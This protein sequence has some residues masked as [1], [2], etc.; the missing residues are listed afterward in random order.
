MP[1]I[2]LTSGF[3]KSY[4]LSVVSDHKYCSQLIILIWMI[5]YNLSYH[6]NYFLLYSI[7]LKNLK[8]PLRPHK[9]MVFSGSHAP[10]WEPVSAHLPLL[11]VVINMPKNSDRETNTPQVVCVVRRTHPVRLAI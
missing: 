3:L 10:A 5:N 6:K 4:Q 9:G 11:R 7:G 8:T 2:R 1:Q